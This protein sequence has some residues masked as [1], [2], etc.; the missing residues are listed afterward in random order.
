MDLAKIMENFHTAEYQYIPALGLPK[1][2]E[3][4][5]R[6]NNPPSFNKPKSVLVVGLPAVEA[7][8]LP[9]MRAVDPNQV[10]CV[11]APSLVL[12]VEGAPLVFATELAHDF[13]LHVH[14]KSGKD[15]D[16]PAKADAARG[17]FTVDAHAL[18]AEGLDPEISG[19][20]RG[21]WG[22]DRFDGPTFHMR[23]PQNGK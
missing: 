2:D 9:P 7:P 8:Q 20:L 19:T 3:L 13:E 12:P 16:L 4:S 11:T 18:R 22:F 5:L 10:F 6:L 1:E 21:Y 14:S 15:L 23:S 17:G